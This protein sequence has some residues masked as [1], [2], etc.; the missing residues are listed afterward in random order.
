[1]VVVVTCIVAGRVLELLATSQETGFRHMT[2][3]NYSSI[4]SRSV[5]NFVRNSK[6]KSIYTKYSDLCFSSLSTTTSQNHNNLWIRTP[7]LANRGRGHAQDSSRSRFM[8][9]WIGN[10]YFDL[11]ASSQGSTYIC[12]RPINAR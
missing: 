12:L 1:M 11:Y 2:F 8:D 9:F 6:L 5:A 3:Y 7:A 4:A 10:I